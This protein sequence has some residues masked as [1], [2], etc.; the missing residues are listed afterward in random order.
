MKLYKLLL[1][2]KVEKQSEEMK[3]NQYLA[4][5]NP[6]IETST[7]QA[8]QERDQMIQWSRSQAQQQLEEQKQETFAIQAHRFLFSHEA[9]KLKREAGELSSDCMW[10]L[11]EENQLILS[12]ENYFVIRDYSRFHKSDC[13]GRK[14]TFF[15]HNCEERVSGYVV[16][17]Y[18][19]ASSMKDNTLLVSLCFI[20][21]GRY[22]ISHTTKTIAPLVT[23]AKEALKDAQVT[24]RMRGGSRAILPTDTPIF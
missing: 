6:Y 15:C 23:F 18:H 5:W 17:H 11:T 19:D 22:F 4:Q 8:Y 10:S 3:R 9:E 13:I 14:H 24:M 21:Q 16:R 1:L 7:L 20:C 12:K 2:K